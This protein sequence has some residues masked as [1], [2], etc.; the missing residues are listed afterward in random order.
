[1]LI[2]LPFS[3]D[4]YIYLYPYESMNASNIVTF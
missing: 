1:M 2:T 3:K 4:M